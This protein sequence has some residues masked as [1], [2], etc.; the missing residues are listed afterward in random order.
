M[1]EFPQGHGRYS[2]CK[3]VKCK[4]VK[5]FAKTHLNLTK[6]PSYQNGRCLNLGPGTRKNIITSDGL[7]VSI[8]SEDIPNTS[9]LV[10]VVFQDPING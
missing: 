10:K 2:R 1:F 9:E 3:N 8:Y 6:N 5:S 4:N 7:S